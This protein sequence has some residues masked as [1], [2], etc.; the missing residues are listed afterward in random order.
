[1]FFI[2]FLIGRSGPNWRC[3][4]SRNTRNTGFILFSVI[5]MTC[6]FRFGSLCQGPIG[7]TGP[8]GL[9]GPKGDQGDQGQKGDKGNQGDTGIQVRKWLQQHSII[10]HTIFSRLQ[11]L[12]GITGPQ[13]IQGETGPI[14]PK[15]DQGNILFFLCQTFSKRY[16]TMLGEKG[17]KGI[18]G[19]QGPEVSLFF[20]KSY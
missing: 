17:D 7:I 15:G 14:G 8:I 3:W 5:C 10:M 11:G 4:Y 16:Y 13:G 6:Y 2:G 12:Q 19:P 1:M 20:P 18:I 9:T